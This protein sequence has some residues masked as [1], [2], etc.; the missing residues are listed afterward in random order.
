M[1]ILHYHIIRVSTAPGASSSTIS[2]TKFYNI[3]LNTTPMCIVLHDSL[4]TVI[5]RCVVIEPRAEE[6]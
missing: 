5:A 3:L 6:L 4:F 2:S 1:G